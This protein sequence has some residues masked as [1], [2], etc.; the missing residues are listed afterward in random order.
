MK[1][2]VSAQRFV[3]NEIFHREMIR[4]RCKSGR[5]LEGS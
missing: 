4:T 5:F 2:V 1:E 3:T